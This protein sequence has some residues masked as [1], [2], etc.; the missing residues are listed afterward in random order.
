M[1]LRIVSTISMGLLAYYYL[2]YITLFYGITNTTVKLILDFINYLLLLFS[3]ICF[4]LV[5]KCL[6]KKKNTHK[7]LTIK[8]QFA[9]Q[10][11]KFIFLFC[12]LVISIF[13]D[14]IAMKVPLDN[15]IPFTNF[16][17]GSSITNLAIL[18]YYV[19]LCHLFFFMMKRGLESLSQT[20]SHS[21]AIY[22]HTTNSNN[23]VADYFREFI[24]WK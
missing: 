23:N 2:F 13:I 12:I 21:K 4:V 11:R 22:E 20:S 7:T 24:W 15:I 6:F 8:Q 10:K 19:I 18:Y 5:I 16:F 1:K 14:F 17:I 3:M 9:K